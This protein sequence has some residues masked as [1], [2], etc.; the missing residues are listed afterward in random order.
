MMQ[1]PTC[2]T[3]DQN[4]YCIEADLTNIMYKI[5]VLDSSMKKMTLH[6]MV[7]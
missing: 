5:Y 3:Q 1:Q 4:Y 2:M 7:I 6:K